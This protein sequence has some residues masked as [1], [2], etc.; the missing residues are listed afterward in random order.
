MCGACKHHLFISKPSQT[1]ESNPIPSIHGLLLSSHHISLT[2]ECN[3]ALRAFYSHP[4]ILCRLYQT[5]L[6]NICLAFIPSP[7]Q[8]HEW[9]RVCSVVSAVLGHAGHAAS[10]CL[11]LLLPQQLCWGVAVALCRALGTLGAVSPAWLVSDSQRS[12]GAPY[13][14]E[15]HF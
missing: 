6:P 9:G 11:T 15:W 4:G 2:L 8:L 7:F 3:P 12:L 13:F 5:L 10:P 1:E 14:W